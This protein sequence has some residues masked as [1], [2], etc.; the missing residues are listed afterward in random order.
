MNDPAQEFIDNFIAH[1][2]SEYYDPAKAREYYLRTRELKGRRSASG[3]K[4][5]EKKQA[6]TYAKGQIKEAEKA[7][8]TTAAESRK[9]K[10]E[11]LRAQASDR[12]KQISGKLKAVL[13]NMTLDRQQRAERIS[14]T[15]KAKIDR[16]NKK[17][18]REAKKIAEEAQRKIDALPSIPEGVSKEKRAE[19]V[20]KRREEI[21]KIRGDSV[22][23]RK[24]LSESTKAERSALTD[25]A[26]DER[27]NLSD[28]VKENKKDE[29]ESAKEQREEVR[30]V[31][32]DS[33]QKARD[34]YEAFKVDL[35]AK[36]ELELQKEYD[37]IKKNV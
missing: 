36:Y 9:G 19:L 25:K 35:K 14:K 2:A 26:S 11:Q 18:K 22:K 10:V 32:K 4:S 7:E 8:K 31:L 17:Q 37:A 13:L 20:A 6:W 28:T 33:V 24:A 21:A 5:K 12:R 15:Q 29:R 30:T 34:E 23:Q 3:L 16:L 27:E 1:Y